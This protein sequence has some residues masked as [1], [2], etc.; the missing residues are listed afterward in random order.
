MQGEIVTRAGSSATRNP[1]STMSISSTGVI[2]WSSPVLGSFNVTL[3]ADNGKAYA[4]QR[5]LLTVSD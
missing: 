5:Y 3:R 4:E 2:S 1:R